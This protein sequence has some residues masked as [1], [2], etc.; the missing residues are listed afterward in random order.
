MDIYTLQ[1]FLTLTK[2]QEYLMA[3]GGMILFTMFWLYLDSRPK[4]LKT[5]SEHN[6]SEGQ[7]TKG[8]QV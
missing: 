1:D 7:G 3:I 8:E 2:G 5:E 4:N 6:P